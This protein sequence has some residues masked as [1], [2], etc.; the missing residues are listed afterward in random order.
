MN[1]GVKFIL[2]YQSPDTDE[3]NQLLIS[4]PIDFAELSGY[5]NYQV[6]FTDGSYL[7]RDEIEDKYCKWEIIIN[8][9]EVTI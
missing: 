7:M 3:P 1:R 9:H 8:I 2:T 5:C 6:D 4:E